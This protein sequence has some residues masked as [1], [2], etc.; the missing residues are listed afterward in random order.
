MAYPLQ[1]RAT[2]ILKLG[3][4]HSDSLTSA[5]SNSEL[6]HSLRNLLAASLSHD[7]NNADCHWSPSFSY[8]DSERSLF[9]PK[10]DESDSPDLSDTPR[11]ALDV[12]AKLFCLQPQQEDPV[13][14][15]TKAVQL[16]EQAIGLKGVDLLILQSPDIH[17][18]ADQAES[19][20]DEKALIDRERRRYNVQCS[21]F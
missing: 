5:K 6:V 13:Q 8:Q 11:D 20:A 10:A 1:L 4:I 21:S 2:S 14:Q 19:A 9:I 18:E 3:I 16:L 7:C 17:Y 12:T 15:T